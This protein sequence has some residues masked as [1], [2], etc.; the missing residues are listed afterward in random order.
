[1]RDRISLAL[2]ALGLL[3]AVLVVG[4]A[5][6]W[7]QALV[8][9]L[10]ALAL[11]VQILA[12]RRLE[13]VS[14][15]IVLPAIAAV[16]CAVQLLPLPGGL[17]SAL[18]HTGQQLRVDGA[19]IAHTTPWMSASLDPA[20]TLRAFAFF[21]TLLGVAVLSTRFAAS[22]RGRL[23]LLG[24]VSITCG[25][26]AVITGVHT[27]IDTHELYGLYTPQHAGGGPVFGPLLNPNH[28]GGLMAIGA[29]LSFGLA[30]YQRQA[31]QLRV[32]WIMIG[33]GCVVVGAF[34]LSRGA[35]IGMMIGLFV[36]FAVLLGKR[37][38]SRDHH[39]GHALRRDL[40][41][42]IVI[43]VGLAVALYASAGNVADQ[44]G[45]TSLSE[46]NR[47]ISK[48]QAWKSSLALVKESPW[49]GVGR[50]AVE[51]T[52]T[53]V[54]PASAQYTFSHL[55]N[56]YITAVVEFG[57]PGAAILAA[58]FGWFLL[59]ALR[60]RRDGPLAAAALG[61]LAAIMFQSTVDFGIEL[62]GIAVPVTI[63]AATVALVP[64]RPSAS[65]LRTYLQRGAVIAL[66]GIAALVL[67]SP[68]TTSVQEDHDDI[69]AEP[70]PQLDDLRESIQRHPL[71]YFG[72]GLAADTLTRT[73]DPIAAQYLNHALAL[74]PSHPGLHR[75]T[76]RLLV[77]LRRYD[78]AALEYSN[79]MSAQAAPRQLLEEIVALI[80]NAK[81]AAAALP[82]DY[83]SVEIMLHSLNDMK[84]DDIAE[85]WL[86]RIAEQ[87]QHD[88]RIIDTLYDLATKRRD[89]TVAK[90]AAELR[91]R[92]SHTNTSRLM[93]AK[94]RFQLG[95]YDAVLKDLGD[96]HKWTGRIDEKAD[97]WLLTCDVESQRKEWD[98]ALECLHRLD[99]S[100]LPTVSHLD[101]T[102][103]IQEISE[104]RTV[105]SKM[106]AIKAMEHS[107][108]A[109]SSNA[110]TVTFRG[111]VS[112]GQTW[113]DITT[114]GEAATAKQL[115]EA[116]AKRELE[117]TAATI[118]PKLERACESSTLPGIRHDK[119]YVLVRQHEVDDVEI[120]MA[121]KGHA[122]PGTTA[123]TEEL[124]LFKT[125]E[126]C[127][128]VRKRLFEETQRANQEALKSVSAALAREIEAARA[129]R[130]KACV[131]PTEAS[132]ATA[133]EKLKILEGAAP[134]AL[135]TTIA[136]CRAE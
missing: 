36:M 108:S 28:M 45:T 15:L 58:I 59:T 121:T 18:D 12:R 86:A 26:A 70:V 29:V 30:F 27:L 51:P 47:P 34:S 77:G 131:T 97:A 85:E 135:P 55:E 92:V 1:M 95:E 122:M 57:I 134:H 8:A 17:L 53:R 82:V 132:C 84:R 50:N 117:L 128:E 75:L 6:R 125:S 114:T 91:S 119:G 98:P 11:L 69:L 37:L 110:P 20:G 38:S 136:S 24:A 79:A 39:R 89:F 124:D 23:M 5:L 44:V 65:P 96:V 93:L 2:A 46:L 120:M 10:F 61:A 87:P 49:I 3:T 16:L 42:A 127:E 126:R 104:Q 105:E 9:G 31:T 22:E 123:M 64:L 76:A 25:L 52:L 54:Y 80:P 107:L 7:T 4:G 14:P 100:G 109:P 56:E 118:S 94:A 62:L 116:F 48:Y 129:Q 71:D 43:G 88:V 115:C 19:S 103:R 73:G 101:I 102:K 13:R 35:L 113:V 111:R 90:S 78:Q 67:L 130:D 133:K 83:P 32:M 72:F 66:L 112:V 33:I 63:I 99:A 41:V 21:I 74:H 68:L 60:R 40:P 81:Q 106:A